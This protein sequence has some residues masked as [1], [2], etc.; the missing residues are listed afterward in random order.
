[1]G[2]FREKLY[3]FMYGRSGTD[4]LY[5]FLFFLFFL[6]W[7]VQLILVAFMPN[8]LAGTIVSV[9]FYV[10]TFLI[11]FFMIFRTMSRKVY[12]RRRENEIYLKIRRA[13]SRLF[14]GNTST[15]TKSRNIDTAEFVFRDCT[16]CGA[17]LRLRRKPGRHK[18]KCPRCSHSFYV[19]SK[20]FGRK[21]SGD[22]I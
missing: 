2:N 15:K 11:I 12:K 1:M 18:V 8:G 22:K 4:E 16:K 14:K 9:V 19:K 20:H 7:V 3:R 21:K 10:L 17:T 6:I 5:Y 13:I